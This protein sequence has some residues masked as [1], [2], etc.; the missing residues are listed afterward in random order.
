M[1]EKIVHRMSNS[2]GPMLCFYQHKCKRGKGDGI[3]SRDTI[4]EEKLIAA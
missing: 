2:M 1:L 3:F 4:V